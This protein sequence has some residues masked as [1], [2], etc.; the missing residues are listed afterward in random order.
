[1]EQKTKAT[2][3][4]LVFICDISYT[5]SMEHIFASGEPVPTVSIGKIFTPAQ[6]FPD[7][8]SFVDVLIKNAFVISGV[9]FFILLIFGGFTFIVSAGGGDA[10][11]A[12]QSK[13]TITAAATGLVLIFA[14]Y[15]I[16]QIIE[17][18]TGVKILNL[19]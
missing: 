15:W 17:V 9:I 14:S 5:F 13:Q 3:P 2:K 1:M 10:K 7:V 6:S 11:K 4:S 19:K 8:A 18:I 16:I 12:E